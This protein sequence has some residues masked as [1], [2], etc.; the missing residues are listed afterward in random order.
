MKMFIIKSN[1]FLEL[2]KVNAVMLWPFIFIKP[3]LADNQVLVNHEK[4][5]VAQCKE[6]LVVF[7][8]LWYILEW[9]IRFCW[10]RRFY[11]AYLNLGFEQE[12]YHNQRNL[13]Y[14]EKRKHF[15]WL[16]KAN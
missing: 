15:A 13:K 7:F 6:M 8:Y 1:W 9:F 4:I 5:H 10:Y 16:R 2:I 14:L 12:A 11:P 3:E